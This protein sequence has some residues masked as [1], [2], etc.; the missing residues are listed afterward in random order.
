MF[1]RKRSQVFSGQVQYY[2][3][4][5]CTTLTMHFAVE[6]TNPLDGIVKLK[7]MWDNYYAES[8][9]PRVSASCDVPFRSWNGVHEV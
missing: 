2:S 1:N 6:A 9:G 5:R 7:A 8:Y 4:E 3:N